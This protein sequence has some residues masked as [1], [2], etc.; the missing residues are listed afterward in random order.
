MKE[1]SGFGSFA[2]AWTRILRIEF[3]LSAFVMLNHTE[4]CPHSKHPPFWSI[5]L[6]ANQIRVCGLKQKADM[7]KPDFIFILSLSL[8]FPFLQGCRHTPSSETE[9]VGSQ[10]FT[11]QVREAMILLK[12]RDPDAYAIVT[13]YVGR[14]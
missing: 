4:R 11:S 13:N 2:E 7:K 3:C 12:T 1:W 5:W 8:A 6:I 9:I 14:I 10:R